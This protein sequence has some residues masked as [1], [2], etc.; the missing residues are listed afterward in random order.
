A[1]S[2][3]TLVVLLETTAVV[4][5]VAQALLSL[6][7]LRL[8]F[9]QRWYLVSDRSLRTR[10]GLMEL[11]ERTLTFANI[12]NVSI[13]QGPLQRLLGIADI[14]IRTAGGGGGSSTDDRKKTHAGGDLH[15]AY[16]RGLGDP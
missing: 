11:H 12:Q 10:E 7:M 1:G 8:D 14:E 5:F 16:L 6:A 13:M 2:W 9:E 4:V 3:M 15:T